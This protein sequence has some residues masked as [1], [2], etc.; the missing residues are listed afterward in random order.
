MGLL[1]CIAGTM[2]IALVN[3]WIFHD[4]PVLAF[5]PLGISNGPKAPKPWISVVGLFWRTPP[6]EK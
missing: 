2:A 6:S 3:L 5:P 1:W 4:H